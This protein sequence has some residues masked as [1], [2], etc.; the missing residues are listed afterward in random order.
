MNDNWPRL[1][2][3][4]IEA[5]RD[6]PFVWGKHDCCLFA[7]DVVKAMTGEDPMTE[8]RGQYKD[9]ESALRALKEIG[10]GNLYQTMRRKFGNPRRPRRGYVVYY[11]KPMPALGICIGQNCVFVGQEGTKEGLVTLPTEGMRGFCVG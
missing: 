1:M 5:V 8:F 6:K 10:S 11:N 7:A 9:Q 2:N 4:A 3:E